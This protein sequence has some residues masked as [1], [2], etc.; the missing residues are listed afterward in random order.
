M[1]AGVNIEKLLLWK[2]SLFVF[3]G[4]RRKKGEGGYTGLHIP[5]DLYESNRVYSA[6]KA[7][8]RKRECVL[9]LLYFC[10]CLYAAMTRRSLPVVKGR[11]PLKYHIE[12]SNIQINQITNNLS[13]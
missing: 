9:Q 6:K 3:F 12:I 11:G 2:H 8:S 4:M 1:G 13:K 10:M 7:D 5:F